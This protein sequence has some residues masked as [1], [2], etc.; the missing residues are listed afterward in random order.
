MPAYQHQFQQMAGG[1]KVWI[2]ICSWGDGIF[3]L[4]ELDDSTL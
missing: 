3:K 4:F 1:V 2:F